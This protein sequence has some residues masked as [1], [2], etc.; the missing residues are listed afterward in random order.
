[1]SNL[2]PEPPL[3]SDPARAGRIAEVL[4]AVAHPL[5]LRIVASLCREE[6]NVSTL[7]ERL[8]ASQAIVSQQLRIL[9]SL[10]LVA[11][12]REDG[13]ARYRLAEPA[14]E[15]LVCCMERCER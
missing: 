8:G 9:R 4:K 11:A 2:R 13:F 15:D 14:L 7:A 10:G 6:L 1:M 3:A 5:R 12:T